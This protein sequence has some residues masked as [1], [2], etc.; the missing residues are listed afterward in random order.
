MDWR[1]SSYSAEN[2]NCAEAA[3]TTG[4]VLVRDTA[5]RAGVTLAVPVQAWRAFTAGVKAN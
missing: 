2:G 1:K 5:D 3:T 4:G